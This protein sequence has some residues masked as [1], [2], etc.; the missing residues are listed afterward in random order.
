M[1]RWIRAG[2]STLLI[3]AMLPVSAMAATLQ[4]DF[5]K[6][7]TSAGIG[8]ADVIG[9]RYGAE[10]TF[11]VSDTTD[12]QYHG[13][14]DAYAMTINSDHNTVT[15]YAASK[16]PLT[17]KDGVLDLGTLT[18][19][20]G[21]EVSK[22][23]GAVVLDR[24]LNRTEYTEGSDLTLTVN[25]ESDNTP[26]PSPTPDDEDRTPVVSVVGKGGQ[27]SAHKD[28]TVTIS[29]DS[30]Y[31]IAK[32]LVNG[33]EVAISNTLTGLSADDEVEVTF[34]KI[35]TGG[36]GGGNTGGST[37]N[38]G[39]DENTDSGSD[40]NTAGDNDTVGDN[41]EDGDTTPSLN[42]TD[43]QP[44]D[45][46]AE[47]VAFAVE[48]GLFAGTS[49][50]TFSP[51]VNMTRAMLVA[52][53]YRHSG[54]S[55]QNQQVFDDVAADAWYAEPIAWAKEKGVV[56]GMTETTFAPDQSITREQ[57]ATILM[58]YTKYM[59]IDTPAGG[60]AIKGYSDYGSISSYA[61]ASMAWA[62]D[63]GLISGTTSSTLSPTSGA[64]RA[65][66]ATILMRYVLM[67]DMA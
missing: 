56:A 19:A 26:S 29:V 7:G 42:F 32:I 66:V 31:R 22:V 58:R 47:P 43:V 4:V 45:W 41:E 46:F 5:D 59:G 20:S 50:T 8:L 39:N 9:D 14:G 3:G 55:V 33:K 16:T 18:V 37:D 49:A 34:E 60:D 38:G 63:Q 35:T 65:Q 30:G 64:T 13:I 23:N 28:G 6:A 67:N 62:V 27:V 25:R 61:L 15:L 11:T 53:L 2:V 44:N 12:L 21:S 54:D 52:V 40:D 36:G 1:K 10:V 57:M 48:H 17:V 51:N 24:S